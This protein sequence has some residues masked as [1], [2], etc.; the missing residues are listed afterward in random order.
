MNSA[1]VGWN[2]LYVSIRSISFMVFFKSEASLLIF[3]LEDQSVGV[4]GVLKS[5]SIIVFGS[6]CVLMSPRVCFMEVAAP[7][8]VLFLLPIKMSCFVSFDKLGLEV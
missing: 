8:F 2:I 6:T 7:L 4:R 5:P 1:I 3:C